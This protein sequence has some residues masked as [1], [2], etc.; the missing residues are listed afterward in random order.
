MLSD[1]TTTIRSIVADDFR[2]AAVFEKHGIDFCCGG[3]RP[4][5]DVCG[6]Q[7]LDGRQI[8][9][10]LEEALAS[11][12]DVP[13]FNSWDL[14]FLA[15]YIVSNHH[16]YVRQA[17]DTIGAH[18]RKVADVH[19]GHH[20]EVKEIAAAFAAIAAEMAQ[21]MLKEERMLFPY[22]GQLAAAA[23]VRTAPSP[24]P[25]G[26]VANPIRM[27]EA[28]HQSAGDTMATIRR[29]SGDY[30][31]PADA[32]T[33]FKVTYQ[34]LQAFEADLHRHVHLENNILFPKALALERTLAEIVTPSSAP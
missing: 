2:A 17:I 28:E 8:V 27:M 19:G 22:I 14:D 15:N 7:G 10:D 29:L 23:R 31:L 11:E 20:P 32:C 33:T 25:F 18:T 9:A 16:A 34:E 13:R 21:H 1:P 6:E 3:N 12:V 30:T 4:I 24:A 5:A 26:S